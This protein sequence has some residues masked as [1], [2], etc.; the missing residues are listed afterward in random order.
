MREINSVIKRNQSLKKFLLSFFSEGNVYEEKEVNG[1]HL[2]KQFSKR[3]NEWNVA[4][5]SKESFLKRKNNY[6]RFK[7]TFTS[8]GNSESEIK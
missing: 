7:K 2:V 6:M 1:F 8:R 3:F 4:I 5:F